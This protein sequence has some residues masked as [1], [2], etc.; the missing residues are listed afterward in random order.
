[1]SSNF[2]QTCGAPIE[3][4]AKFC[5]NC[6][7]PVKSINICPHCGG[8][9][10]A[11][12]QFCSFCGERVS[13]KP[14][15]SAHDQPTVVV[16]APA[17]SHERETRYAERPARGG[18]Y[19]E[20]VSAMPE[21][22]DADG[23]DVVR[24]EDYYAHERANRG[25]VSHGRY[26]EDERESSSYRDDTPED[27]GLTEEERAKQ[28][29]IA[30]RKAE[31][32]ENQRLR[33]QQDELDDDGLPH[34][35]REVSRPSDAD[36]D[37][38][39]PMSFLSDRARKRDESSRNRNDDGDYYEDEPRD[40]YEDERPRSGKKGRDL[41][42]VQQKGGKLAR[43]QKDEITADQR[44]F[45][46]RA[47]SDGYY[48]DRRV[49]DYDDDEEDGKGVNTFATVLGVVAIAAVGILMVLINGALG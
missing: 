37:F 13:S 14:M 45:Q 4:N 1:M 22:R 26:A 46:Q 35:D 20:D 49:D 19:D 17:P 43:K 44:R 2:C 18:F 23:Y 16:D 9:L 38:G 10:P 15:S 5:L 28:R 36:K 7:S 11:S 24:A 33:E 21:M 3:P 8:E 39:S 47:N 30:R 40:E 27:D 12:A 29:L 48:D 32:E 31:F 25:K 41:A 6:G 34:Y 42:P